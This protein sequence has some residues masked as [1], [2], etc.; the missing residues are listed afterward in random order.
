[1]KEKE[2]FNLTTKEPNLHNHNLP[3]NYNLKENIIEQKKP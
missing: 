3:L 2:N 1:M